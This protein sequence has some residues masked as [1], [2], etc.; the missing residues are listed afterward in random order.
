M[1]SQ[2]SSIRYKQLFTEFLVQLFSHK[3]TNNIYTPYL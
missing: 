2:L 3:G 1:R